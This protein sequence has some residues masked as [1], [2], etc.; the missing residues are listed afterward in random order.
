MI[1][2]PKNERLQGF[3]KTVTNSLIASDGGDDE[4][5]WEGVRSAGKD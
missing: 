3:L 1:L 2:S 4:T 5:F